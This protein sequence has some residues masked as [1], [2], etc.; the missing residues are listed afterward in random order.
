[1][2]CC[3]FDGARWAARGKHTGPDQIRQNHLK[4]AALAWPW[5]SIIAIAPGLPAFVAC[6]SHCPPLHLGHLGCA[7][8]GHTLTLLARL[9]HSQAVFLA[10]TGLTLGTKRCTSA[11]GIPDCRRLLILCPG[12]MV[13]FA[14]DRQPGQQPAKECRH[15]L[16]YFNQL[17]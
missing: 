5:L 13:T 6:V 11:R 16:E 10:H 12:F 9:S 8:I 7:F 14:C 2:A 3:D 1:M 15:K 4:H 17:A